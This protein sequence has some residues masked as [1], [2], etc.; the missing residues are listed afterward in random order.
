MPFVCLHTHALIECM[1][2]E[3][4]SSVRHAART[5]SLL[6]VGR[7]PISGTSLGVPRAMGSPDDDMH[8]QL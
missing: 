2:L 4:V 8:V 3:E 5:A 7:H 6:V 1:W